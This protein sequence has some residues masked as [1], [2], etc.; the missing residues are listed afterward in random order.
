MIILSVTLAFFVCLTAAF[1]DA[2][3]PVQRGIIA[4]LQDCLGNL[5]QLYHLDLSQPNSLDVY[6]FEVR[7]FEKRGKDS[8]LQKCMDTLT[9]VDGDPILSFGYGSNPDLEISSS[10]GELTYGEFV[11]HHWSDWKH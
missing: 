5:T 6:P 10:D 2:I 9:F 7:P 1:P 3:L 11:N 4:Q 8:E